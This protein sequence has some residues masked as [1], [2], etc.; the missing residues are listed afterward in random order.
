MAAYSGKNLWTPET[1]SAQGVWSIRDDLQVPSS[2][3]FLVYAQGK[4]P[5]PMVQE[6]FQSIISQLF[7]YVRFSLLSYLHSKAVVH[8]DVKTENMLLETNKTLKI[9][10]FGVATVEAQNPQD[11]T[12]ETGTLGY[13]SPEKSGALTT[14]EGTKSLNS[15][16][17]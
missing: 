14:A 15:S 6:L 2:P 11:M 9:S 8:R 3:S 7:Q 1:P 5:P 16:F 17:I 10:D 13:M 12:G 4:G